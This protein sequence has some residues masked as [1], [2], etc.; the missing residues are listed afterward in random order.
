MKY[1]KVKQKAPISLKVKKQGREGGREKENVERKAI[2]NTESFK[3]KVF[4]NGLEVSLR[5][6]LTTSCTS[7]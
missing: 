3:M 4:L 5:T 7:L 1:F 6:G 2:L